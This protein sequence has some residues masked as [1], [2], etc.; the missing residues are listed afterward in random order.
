MIAVIN[1]SRQVYRVILFAYPSRLRIE[2]GPD[3]LS[4]F[5]QQLLDARH[6]GG[7]RQVCRVWGWALW[8]TTRIVAFARLEPASIALLSMLSSSA[9]FLLLCWAAGF[10]QHCVK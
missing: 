8:E 1:A 5:E 10:A 3:M 6:E 4:V 7:L 9:L 2:F